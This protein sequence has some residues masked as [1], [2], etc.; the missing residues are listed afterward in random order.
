MLNNQKK[1]IL[2]S[3]Y[4]PDKQESM[5]LFMQMFYDSYQSKNLLVEVWYPVVFF[6]KIETGSG[7]GIVDDVSCLPG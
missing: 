4:L 1:I 6:G 3:N 2:I 5:R 7:I